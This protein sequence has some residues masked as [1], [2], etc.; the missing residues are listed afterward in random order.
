MRRT[1]WQSPK[2]TYQER[3]PADNPTAKRA[4]R[5]GNTTFVCAHNTQMDVVPTTWSS[6]QKHRTTN[7]S[8]KPA[9]PALGHVGVDDT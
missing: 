1:R 4:A 5:R 6:T 7:R 3:D 2:T 8:G 9:G